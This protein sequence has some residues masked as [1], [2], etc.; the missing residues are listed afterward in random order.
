MPPPPDG[1]AYPHFLPAALAVLA[2]G[3]SAFPPRRRV[4]RATTL[5]DR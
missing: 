5:D 4:V 1:G 2:P 3:T